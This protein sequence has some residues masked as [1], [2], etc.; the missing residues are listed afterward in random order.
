MT[1]IVFKAAASTAMVSMT[2]M[3]FSAQSDAM[4]RL[5]EPARATSRSDRQ[6]EALHEQAARALHQGQLGPAQSA[7]EQAVALSPRDS[8]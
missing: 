1:R 3:G 6:A 5:G 4:R 2:M 8:G 7:M